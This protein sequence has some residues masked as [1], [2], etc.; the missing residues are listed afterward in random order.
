MG[1]SQATF[2]MVWEP[3]FV[4]RFVRHVLVLPG[5]IL[6]IAGNIPRSYLTVAVRNPTLL[7]VS[8]WGL[9]HLWTNGDLAS[10]L[11]FGSF[12]IWSMIRFALLWGVQGRTSSHPSIVWDAVTI[13]LGSLFYSVIVVYHG[14]QFGAGLNFD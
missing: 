3:L 4:W 13:L 7:G 1:P 8:F 5:V 2:L 10:I 14:H 12:T 11:M 9:A 6:V